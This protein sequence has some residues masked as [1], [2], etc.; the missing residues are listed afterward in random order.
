[1]LW[2]CS[3]IRSNACSAALLI[4]SWKWAVYHRQG[5]GHGSPLHLVATEEEWSHSNHTVLHSV[6]SSFFI[7]PCI[8]NHVTLKNDNF[9]YTAFT[10]LLI[11]PNN[12]LWYLLK[13]RTTTAKKLK[14]VC[15]LLDHLNCLYSSI[16]ANLN[17]SP[18][19]CDL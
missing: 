16:I 18:Y 7:Q 3:Q 4:E 8:G 12:I 14:C 19:I 2:V 11:S 1:M 5:H 13:L 9:W 6:K 15:G 10:E 17:F